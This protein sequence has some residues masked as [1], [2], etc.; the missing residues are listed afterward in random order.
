[1]LDMPP[2]PGIEIEVQIEMEGFEGVL[3]FA[4]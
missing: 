3:L 4:G 2:H 1:M